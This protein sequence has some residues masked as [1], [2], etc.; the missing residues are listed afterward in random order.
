MVLRSW[1]VCAA[2]AACLLVSTAAAQQYQGAM[3]PQQGGYS[4]LAPNQPSSYGNSPYRISGQPGVNA[5]DNQGPSPYRIAERSNPAP[6]Q[7]AMSNAGASILPTP[8]ATPRP[9][10]AE[11]PLMP[12]LRWARDSLRR[13]ETNLHDYSAV[14]VKRERHEGKVSNYEYMFIKVRHKPLS[15]YL[16]FL[17]PPAVKGQ[18]VIYVQGQNDGKMLAHPVGIRQKIVG[19]VKLDP[20]GPIAMRGNHYPITE[21]GMLNLVRRMIEVGDHD[22]QYGECE[23]KFMPGAKVNGRTC[24]CLQIV[25]PVPRREFMFHIARIFVDDELIVPL[26]LEAYDWPSQPGGQPEL[27]EEYTYLNVKINNGFTDADFDVRNPN[28]GFKVR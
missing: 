14:M 1:A 18:E 7:P 20:N 6:S 5:A 12:A 27:I 22:A 11:H 23:V 17:D 8:D 16:Y 13:M 21:I 9:Q 25:H 4:S 28:Y 10:P 3:P 2:G 15:V 26:R 24:T 19:T